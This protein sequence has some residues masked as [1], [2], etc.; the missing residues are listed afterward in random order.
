[1]PFPKLTKEEIEKLKI[2]DGFKLHRD[3]LF[4][5]VEAP[6]RVYSFDVHN[7][8]RRYLAGIV[9]TYPIE[10]QKI[11]WQ[12]IIKNFILPRERERWIKEMRDWLEQIKL[13]ENILP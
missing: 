8:D 13:D 11:M 5:I 6:G 4:L 10:A 1:M 3:C 9:F 7:K 2:V 12:Y